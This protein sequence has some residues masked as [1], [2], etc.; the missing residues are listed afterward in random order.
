MSSA[1]PGRSYIHGT[2]RR[3][4]ERLDDLNSLT[5]QSFLN[6]LALRGSEAVCDF[7]CGAGTLE[8]E[9]AR[10]YP[11]I[12]VVGVERSPEFAATAR[13]RVATE[14]SISI[15]TADVMDACLGDGEFDVTFCR[16]LLEHVSAPEAVAREMVRVTK[17]GGRIVV[18]ENDLRHVIYHPEVFGHGEV[19]EAFCKL[20]MSMGGDPFIG[21]K[22]FSLFDLEEVE[23]IDVDMSP[24]IHSARQPERYRAWLSNAIRIFAGAAD[25]M[26][27]RGL[28]EREQVDAVLGL[29]AARLEEPRGIALFHWDRVT[30]YKRA[31]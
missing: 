30:A 24:E 20:Q 1:K 22:L 11:R 21:R 4:R 27:E 18:Q 7:G 6:Y 23:H 31:M 26:V 25:E 3:E 8:R 10:R 13:G 16:Y 15:V 29:M 14:S 2:T 19:L 5:N 28:I 12:R 9:L 17:P